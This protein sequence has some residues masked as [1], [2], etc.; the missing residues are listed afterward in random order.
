MGRS[1]RRS[2]DGWMDRT[3]FCGFLYFSKTTLYIYI[4]IYIF[5]IVSGPLKRRFKVSFVKK[6][7]VIKTRERAFIEIN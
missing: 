6:I 5:L 7:K 3:F 1:V 2:V 4:Y